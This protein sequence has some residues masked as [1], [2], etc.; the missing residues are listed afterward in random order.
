MINT[1][2]DDN[3]IQQNNILSLTLF[4]NASEPAIF[5]S[6][7]KVILPLIDEYYKH[8]IPA[9]IIAQPPANGNEVSMEVHALPNYGSD[10][11]TESKQLEGIIYKRITGNAIGK[12]LF[13]SGVA[14]SYDET[15]ALNSSIKVFEKLESILEYEDM[16]FSNIYRQ[17]NYIED[18]LEEHRIEGKI[19]Q[20]YQIF[21]DI[22]SE[23]YKKA[24]V[25]KYPAATGIG[26]RTGGVSISIYAAIACNNCQFLPVDNPLQVSAY[27]YSEDVLIGEPLAGKSTP[28][29][30]RA[31]YF[32]SSLGEVFF[33][34]GT[35]SIRGE[36]T[37]ALNDAV[38]QTRIT[39]ENMQELIKPA[40]LEKSGVSVKNRNPEFKFFRVYVKNQNDLTSIESVC[41]RM[42][43]SAEFL[44]V[45]ADIC[46]NDLLVEI[47]SAVVL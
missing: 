2:L 22:R 40:C 20:N 37:L 24:E 46:R 15:F 45:V 21:N 38:E 28:K 23:F 36:K 43:P 19:V 32:C 5:E 33:I 13:V 42:F 10:I 35:A 4:V 16:D 41:H 47:E 18:I 12:H 27:S 39:L 30:S 11:K 34:S 17:W 8:S 25:S 26:T 31:E 6:K 44:Y 1:W 7:K 29:F 9:C 3:N 14:C